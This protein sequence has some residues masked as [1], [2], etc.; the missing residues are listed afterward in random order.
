MCTLTRAFGVL[1]NSRPFLVCDLGTHRQ[2]HQLHG[3]LHGQLRGQ[4]HGR[5]CRFDCLLFQRLLFT[6]VLPV[7]VC[8]VCC[9]FLGLLFSLAPITSDGRVVSNFIM[10]AL[11]GKDITIYGDGSQTRS[12]CFVDDLIEG[13]VRLMNNEAEVSR[14]A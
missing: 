1:A 12:F 7:F 8:V 13:L 3:Q 11:S 6:A 4:L 5:A 2:N 9:L 10:Q 14:R